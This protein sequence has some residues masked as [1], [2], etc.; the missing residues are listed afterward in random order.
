MTFALQDTQLWDHIIRTARRPLE[1]KESEK[2]NEDRKECIYQRWKKIWDFDLG[3][4]KTGVKISK[5]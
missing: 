1:L 4:R 5:M 2:N 3:V